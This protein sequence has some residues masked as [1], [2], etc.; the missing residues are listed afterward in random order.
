MTEIINY[1]EKYGFSI[2][3]KYIYKYSQSTRSRKVVGQLNEANFYFY[4][5]N[6]A[7]FKAGV[8]YIEKELKISYNSYIEKVRETERNDFEVSFD[9]YINSTK[10]SSVFS[11][12]L[13]SICNKRLSKDFINYYDLRGVKDGYLQDAVC[14]PFIDYN[15]NF[16]TAQIIK[17]DTNGKRIKTAFSQNWYHSYKPIINKIAKE[18]DAFK[19]NV[20]CFFGENYLPYSNNIVGIVEAP[21]T[22]VILKEIYPNIDWIA[23]AG[24]QALFNK[25]LSILE[26]R[27]VVVFSD[28]H[29]TKWK[30]YAE[31]KG[32]GVFDLL[33]NKNIDSGD[34][35]ADHIFY[36]ESPVFYDLHNRLFQI[37]KGVFDITF[38]DNLEFD[39][40]IVGK[41]LSFFAPVPYSF[42]KK[43]IIHKTDN[44]SESKIIHKGAKFDIYE[45]KFINGTFII[46]TWVL[47]ANVDFHAQDRKENGELQQFNE[48]SFI[49]H[50]QKCYRILKE[51]NPETYLDAF[52]FTLNALNDHSNFR[53]NK[54]FVLYKMI[55]TWDNIKRELTDFKKYR[56]WRYKWQDTLTRKEF[57]KSLNDDKFRAKLNI[58]L[59]AFKDV[60]KE[61]RFIDVETDLG[62]SP[63]QKG[64]G[65]SKLFELVKEWNEKVVGAKTLKSYLRNVEI[66]FLTK[67]LHPYIEATYRGV[68]KMFKN[69]LIKEIET[70]SEYKKREIA[71]YLNFKTNLNVRDLINSEVNGMIENINSITIYRMNGKICNFVSKEVLSDIQ[72]VQLHAGYWN[73]IFND[74]DSL[75]QELKE[76]ELK[77]VNDNYIKA[78]KDE[79]K[80]LKYLE[81]KKNEKLNKNQSFLMEIIPLDSEI[82]SNNFLKLAI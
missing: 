61:N 47:N 5:D 14:F 32:W 59:L 36:N 7:P 24:E 9:D 76:Q 12:F 28:A 13:L 57:E 58:H 21:K 37:N 64:R 79:I 46:N 50:L 2:Q 41:S 78:I 1:I 54:D 10:N 15:G 82:K 6:V 60:L 35:I 39:F 44:Y 56:N 80:Y 48:T 23:T 38:T 22:A 3:G 62:L 69:K 55:P 63:E 20:N 4:S 74:S 66:E 30:D 18:N 33:D 43:D 45:K 77:D 11:D 65:Y 68:K 25:D 40:R 75:E 51:L 70:F 34:D 26:N 52:K 8:N 31:K 42:N 17:Y 16:I 73:D 29:T 67:F 72:K 53:F 19:V 81:N 27:K 71:G 49:F